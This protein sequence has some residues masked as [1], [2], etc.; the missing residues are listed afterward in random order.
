MVMVGV[1][2]L[3]GGPGWGWWT[4]WWGGETYLLYY[5][6]YTWRFFG[7]LEFGRECKTQPGARLRVLFNP[8]LSQTLTVTNKLTMHIAGF[9]DIV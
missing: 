8:S 3:G 4:W 1:R 6:A 2:G 9:F 7:V 5:A